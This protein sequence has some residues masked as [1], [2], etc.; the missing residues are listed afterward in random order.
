MTKK[1]SLLALLI[2]A[3]VAA[4]SFVAFRGVHAST[5]VNSTAAATKPAPV[6]VPAVPALPAP[7][8]SVPPVAPPGTTLHQI[9]KGVTLPKFVHQYL[10]QTTYMTKGEFVAAIISRIQIFGD[11]GE[12]SPET[13]RILDHP[14][15]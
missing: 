11:H 4:F 3:L 5:A 1:I 12:G 15:H 7:E 2:V 6:S 13:G 14:R 8:A 9:A 10:D